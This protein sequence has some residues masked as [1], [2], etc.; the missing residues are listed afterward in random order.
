ML[1][2]GAAAA[3]PGQPDHPL[4]RTSSPEDSLHY[5]IRQTGHSLVKAADVMAHL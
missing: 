5:Y 4:R 3:G 2:R 1:N